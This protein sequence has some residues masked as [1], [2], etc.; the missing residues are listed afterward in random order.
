MLP[1]TGVYVREGLQ[2]AITYKFTLFAQYQS[3]VGDTGAVITATTLPQGM[4]ESET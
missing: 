1:D 3:E 4:V 2:P